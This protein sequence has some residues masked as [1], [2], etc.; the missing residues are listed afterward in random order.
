MKAPSLDKSISLKTAGTA[1]VTIYVGTV[2]MLA[3]LGRVD[4]WCY[5][6]GHG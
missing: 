4:I 5:H 1:F 3:A 6:S 2:L